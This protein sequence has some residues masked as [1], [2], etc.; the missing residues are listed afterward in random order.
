MEKASKTL[1]S[2]FSGSK[3]HTVLC[4]IVIFALVGQLQAQDDED[5]GPSIRFN[6]G[7][8]TWF[9]QCDVPSAQQNSDLN[10]SFG[11]FMSFSYGKLSLEAIF[12]RGKFDFD[13]RD[14]LERGADGLV[15]SDDIS[16]EKHFTADGYSRKTDLALA[17]RYTFN[18]YAAISLGATLNRREPYLKIFREPVEENGTITLPRDPSNS[19]KLIYTSNQWWISEG[20]HGSVAVETVSSRFAIFYNTAVLILGSE[21]GDTE[22]KEIDGTPIEQFETARVAYGWVGEGADRIRTF[23]PLESR[24]IGTNAGFSF[25]SGISFEVSDRPSLLVFA[26]YS[27][28]FFAEKETDLIDHSKYHGPYIGLS[29]NV[30]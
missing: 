11:P 14:G 5:S 17:V 6:I 12:F 23:T 1:R 2:I 20:F 22:V 8:A 13:A 30:L 24:S 26:G 4:L 25:S 10:P 18:R 7:T 28:K 3:V 15:F 9:N 27:F 16:R 21:T 19:F 29:W